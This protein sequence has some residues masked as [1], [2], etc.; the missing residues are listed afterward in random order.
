MTATTLLDAL[1]A[2]LHQASEYNRHDQMPPAAV[3]W[4]DKERQWE[5]L[6]P[7]L[8]T[9]LTILTLGDYQPEVRQGPAYYLRCML[10]STLEDRLPDGAVP[11]LY[12]P[13]YSRQDIRAVEDCPKALR[14]LAELQYRG[15]LWTHKNGRDWTVPGFLQTSDGGLNIPVQG[16][17]A[18]KEAL[19]RALPRLVHEPLARL[20]SQA[21]LRAAF[22]DE[23]LNPDEVRRLLK[24]MDDPQGWR[25]QLAE[26]EWRSFV[27]LCRNKYE[28]DPEKESNLSAAE[29]LGN[30][31]GG[32]QV[33]WQRY[34]EVPEAYPAIPELLRRAAPSQPNLLGENASPYYPQDNESAEAELRD[35][36][37][38]LE[39]STSSQARQALLEMEE[40]HGHRRQWVW[41]KL[42]QA[43]LALA[44]VHL[45]ELA[46]GSSQPLVGGTVQE[47]AAQYI[48]S[49]QNETCTLLIA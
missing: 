20:R 36:L 40:R 15:V 2:S 28:L 18:S 5:V 48:Y 19:L 37:L 27:S 41:A 31:T 35:A 16:D 26:A 38:A 1:T 32:W 6:L 33:V 21:P 11:I 3:L 13:G 43:P 44:L 25:G 4:P 14:P 42:G 30:P 39:K 23:L 24:W 22:F 29:R 12:L 47:I 10:A 7:L 17:T 46:D 34:S 9:H 49:S 45:L 8:R